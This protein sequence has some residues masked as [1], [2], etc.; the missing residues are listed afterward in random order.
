[1]CLILIKKPKAILTKKTMKDA[2]I[3]NRDGA[4]FMYA[5]NGNLNVIKGF[6]YF[7]MFYRAFRLHERLHPNSLFVLHFRQATHGAS[8]P[9]NCHP[10][11]VN[12]NLAMAHNGILLNMGSKDVSDTLM[13][14]TNIL[15]KLEDR[16]LDNPKILEAIEKYAIESGSKFVFLD[17]ASK[18]TIC[19]EKAGEWEKDIWYSNKWHG[20]TSIYSGY[21]S[22]YYTGYRND[23]KNW[24]QK[25][26]PGSSW[27]RDY[28]SSSIIT[29]KKEC[30]C[31][32]SESTAYSIYLIG[33]KK[34]VR[35]CGYC[36]DTMLPYLTMSC[37][38]CTTMMTPVHN[39]CPFCNFEIDTDDIVQSM[40]ESSGVNK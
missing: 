38:N 39:S 13:F 24:N 16:F 19:N 8:I 11:F 12:P 27:P 35:L 23:Y 26:L 30:F 34:L 1:M 21:N 20:F 3:G 10:F 14:V 15:Q 32:K 18:L 2:F 22:E 17:N 6:M 40:Y 36:Y 7:R 31:C 25:I 9:D 5:V 4:G 29:C 37:P 28:Q 33:E